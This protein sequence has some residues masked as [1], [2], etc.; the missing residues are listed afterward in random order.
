MT[1]WTEEQYQELSRKVA[2]KFG[3]EPYCIMPATMNKHIVWLHD[4]WV[5]IMELCVKYRVG[6]MQYSI[7]K[8]DVAQA[9]IWQRYSSCQLTTDHNNDP[10]LAERVSKML[11][12]MEV[13]L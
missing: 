12:L 10:S 3:L 1:Q 2:E 13:T 8:G 11:A 7:N 9:F 4:D 6:A 5:E